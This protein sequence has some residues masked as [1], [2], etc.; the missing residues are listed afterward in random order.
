MKNNNQNVCAYLFVDNNKNA[1]EKNNKRN[2]ETEGGNGHG[3]SGVIVSSGIE[4]HFIL[5]PKFYAAYQFFF[6]F[7]TQPQQTA[8]IDVVKYSEF[9]PL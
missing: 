3:N 7:C 8:T 4:D 6:F 2:E 9:F 1:N 5:K